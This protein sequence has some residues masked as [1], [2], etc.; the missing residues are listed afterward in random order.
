M[1]HGE[2]ES[3]FQYR[4]RLDFPTVDTNL[5]GEI[6]VLVDTSAAAFQRHYSTNWINL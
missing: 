2:L 6:R 4:A 3:D 5:S 1:D